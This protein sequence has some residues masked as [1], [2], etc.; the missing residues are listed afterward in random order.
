MSVVPVLGFYRVSLGLGLVGTDVGLDSCN[1]LA[2]FHHAWRP[3]HVAFVLLPLLY[4][5]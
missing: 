5:C 1:A 4:R 2:T 3:W